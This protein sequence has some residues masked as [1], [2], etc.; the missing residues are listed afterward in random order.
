VRVRKRGAAVRAGTA[1]VCMSILL[2]FK[3]GDES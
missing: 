2:I 1:T 3:L